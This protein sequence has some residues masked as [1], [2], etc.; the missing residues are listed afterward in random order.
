MVSGEITQ[1]KEGRVGPEITLIKGTTQ[2]FIKPTEGGIISRFRVD[3]TDV[4]FQDQIIQTP[5]GPKRRG[6]NP[7]LFP[8]AG[9]LPGGNEV[10]PN[11]KQHGFARNK[12]W[13][14]KDINAGRDFV[15]LGLTSDEETK[16]VYPYDFEAELKIS[17]DDNKLR[18]ELSVT[19][20][21]E[22][23]M[24]V[25]PGFHPYF[26]VPIEK[27]DEVKTNIPGFNPSEYDWRTSRHFPRQ[28]FVLLQVPDSGEVSIKSSAEFQILVVWSEQDRPHLCIEPWTRETNAILDPEEKIEILPGETANFWIEIGFQKS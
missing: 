5:D 27:R 11:L 17:V 14:V 1:G 26:Q 16:E 8:N 21:S 25:A 13:T 20:L 12:S 10:F 4:F 18:E 3:N 6:G 24:P 9:S 23:P 19:N 22:R 2:A 15:V 28:T 7:L